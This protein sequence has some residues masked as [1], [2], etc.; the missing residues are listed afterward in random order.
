LFNAED[1]A[2]IQAL[3]GHFSHVTTV[4]WSLDGTRLASSS[5]GKVGGELFVWDL[6]R[7]ERVF[8]LTDLP[9]VVLSLAWDIDGKRLISGG[10]DGALCGWDISSGQCLW[11]R[12]GHQGTVSSLRRS[13]DGKTLASGG[14]DGAILLWELSTGDYLQTLPRD[15]PYEGLNITGIKGLTQAQEATLRTLGATEN[16][17]S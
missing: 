15:R 14:E 11:V 7:G 6:Q 1:G 17:Q 3:T 2:L 12:H 5:K 16:P 4:A 9:G 13:P 10:D 8:V